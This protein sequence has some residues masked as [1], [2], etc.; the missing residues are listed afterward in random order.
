MKEVK[1]V[2]E[3]ISK[4]KADF[5]SD[6]EEL[7][8][9]GT[10]RRDGK[11]VYRVTYNNT[12]FDLAHYGTL[13]LTLDKPYRYNTPLIGSGTYSRT[14]CNAINTA[15]LWVGVEDKYEVHIKDGRMVLWTWI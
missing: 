12:G 2:K 7:F 9:V 6:G 3:C 14:D 1:C 13:I 8:G 10:V 5:E 4:A 11:C 15:L